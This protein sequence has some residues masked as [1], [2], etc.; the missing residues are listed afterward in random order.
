MAV[1][2]ID[3]VPA[4]LGSL[5]KVGTNYKLP[6]NIVVTRET[7]RGYFQ[8]SERNSISVWLTTMQQLTTVM[9]TYFKIG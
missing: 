8:S 5:R 4:D 1:P 7:V 9:H 3:R 2:D 6:G